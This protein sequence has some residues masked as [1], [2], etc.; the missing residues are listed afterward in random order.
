[1]AYTAEE[2]SSESF[3]SAS[4]LSKVRGP[5]K[6]YINSLESRLLETEAVLLSLLSH[7]SPEQLKASIESKPP[8]GP[9]Y[10]NLNY[11][12][13]QATQHVALLKQD[14]CRPAYWNSF[15]LDSEQNVRRWWEDRRSRTSAGQIGDAFA[16][17][18]ASQGVF[19]RDMSSSGLHE[20]EESA[21]DSISLLSHSNHVH[22]AGLDLSGD[23][24][25]D[26]NAEPETSSIR[27]EDEPRIIEP[28]TSEYAVA[29]EGNRHNVMQISD[30]FKED[31]IW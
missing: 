3:P 7:V 11:E 29:R 19:V 2:A 9:A 14:V 12:R 24:T 13:E 23:I 20:P 1:M 15:P 17:N 8:F 18:L 28:E 6:H 25:I 26:A 16:P 10:F 27:V 21:P 22:Q 5:P 4:S 30:R 31:F